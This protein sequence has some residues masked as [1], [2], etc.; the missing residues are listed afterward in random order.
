VRHACV[1]S[2]DTANKRFSKMCVSGAAAA[3][4]AR[5]AKIQLSADVVD[6]LVLLY[7]GRNPAAGKTMY[8]HCIEIGQIPS[9][10]IAQMERKAAKQNTA[11]SRDADLDGTLVP[12]LPV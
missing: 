2:A 5:S 3:A 10:T 4:A 11:M 1:A 12:V 6:G 7:A 8:E 9:L